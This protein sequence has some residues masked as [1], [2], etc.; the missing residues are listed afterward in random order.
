MTI[1]RVYDESGRETAVI[2]PV[3]QWR[4]IL[5][6]LEGE[7]RL[8]PADEEQRRQAYEELD[9]GEALDLR[10]AMGEW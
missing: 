6:E 9:R 1:Q 10:E 8:S 2:V 7:A 4:A 5:A 3:E